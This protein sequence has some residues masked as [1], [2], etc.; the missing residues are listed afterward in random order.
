MGLVPGGA[1]PTQADEKLAPVDRTDVCKEHADKLKI[2]YEQEIIYKRERNKHKKN[3]EDME[4]LLET[5]RKEGEPPVDFKRLIAEGIAGVGVVGPGKDAPQIV[6]DQI[7]WF[8]NRWRW[9][10]HV[11]ALWHL[12][13]RLPAEAWNGWSWKKGLWNGLTRV[14]IARSQ[15]MVD[16]Y[17]QLLLETNWL[18][19]IEL[20]EAEHDCPSN[21]QAKDGEKP[22][23]T[24]RTDGS[25]SGTG[26]SPDGSG[27]SGPTGPGSDTGGPG[28]GMDCSTVQRPYAPDAVI[29]PTMDDPQ[30]GPCLPL[31]GWSL[32]AGA[33]CGSPT[34]PGGAGGAP[35]CPPGQHWSKDLGKCHANN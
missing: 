3:I 24:S 33:R 29:I 22:P 32:P 10:N 11:G 6:Q 8:E 26:V 25:G 27:S 35:S 19:G 28:G 2:L 14:E 16:R 21:G 9:H 30:C 4:K 20:L 1:L 31:A 18:I 12:V 17:Y 7:E 13:T 34:T 15:V 5:A 23:Q